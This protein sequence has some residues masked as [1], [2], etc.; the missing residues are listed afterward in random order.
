MENQHQNDME[1]VAKVMPMTSQKSWKSDLG[2]KT[3]TS[4]FYVQGQCFIRVGP[5]KMEQKLNN[6]WTFIFTCFLYH[7]I[8]NML[9]NGSR[10]GYKM[11]PKACPSSFC[12]L[13]KIRFGGPRV[14][15][16]AHGPQNLEKWPQQVARSRKNNIQMTSKIIPGTNLDG[17]SGGARH[18]GNTF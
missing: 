5:S 6:K 8:T 1:K 18:P 4:C 17:N 16:S 12:L 3:T 15:K 7:F 9:L 13:L 2:T 10:G 14:P 11:T